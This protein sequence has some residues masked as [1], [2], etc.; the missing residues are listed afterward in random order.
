MQFIFEFRELGEKNLT[1]NDKAVLVIPH[2]KS[3]ASGHTEPILPE[4]HTQESEINEESEKN[5]DLDES[6]SNNGEVITS[7]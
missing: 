4:T 5:D 2:V 3:I 6:T 1:T 7:S